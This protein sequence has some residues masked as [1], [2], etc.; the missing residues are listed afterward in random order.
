MHMNRDTG[1]SENDE[2]RECGGHKRRRLAD[3]LDDIARECAAQ[4]VLDARPSDEILGYD[5]PDRPA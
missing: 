1:H 4:P 5:E 3:V 2:P